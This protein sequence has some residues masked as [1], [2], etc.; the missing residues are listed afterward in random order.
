VGSDKRGIL[1]VS[2]CSVHDGLRVSRPFTAG[3][4]LKAANSGM[5]S[6]PVVDTWE[7]GGGS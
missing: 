6:R 5:Y 7:T 4:R 2:S 3:A 1:M